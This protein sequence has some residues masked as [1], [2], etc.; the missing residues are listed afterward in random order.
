MQ[1]RR[2]SRARGSI[3]LPVFLRLAWSNMA[4]TPVLGPLLPMIRGQPIL[5]AFPGHLFSLPLRPASGSIAVHPKQVDAFVV[6]RR[7]DLSPVPIEGR[8]RD[9]VADELPRLAC[10][11]LVVPQMEGCVPAHRLTHMPSVVV[12]HVHR[13]A[14]HH[15]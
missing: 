13:R 9:V 5:A 6:V 15:E 3:L 14:S 7:Q 8:A 11:I 12:M 10:S 2:V 1:G 4:G